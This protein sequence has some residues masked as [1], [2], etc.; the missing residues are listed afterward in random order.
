MTHVLADGERRLI[1]V[2]YSGHGSA[3]D[4]PAAEN[5]FE[6]GPIPRGAWLIGPQ[7][8]HTLANKHVLPGAMRLSPA[9]G[10]STRRTEFWIHGDTA[11]HDH[12]ASRGCIVLPRDARDAVARS[13][14]TD[15]EVVHP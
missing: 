11:A 7:L 14:I 9:P 15:L 10:N 2:G 13:G 6:E 1:G 8:D 4:D 3:L 12:T 5:Q